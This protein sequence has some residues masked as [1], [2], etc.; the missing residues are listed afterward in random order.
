MTLLTLLPHRL[1]AVA[2][3]SAICLPAMAAELEGTPVPVDASSQVDLQIDR[4]TPPVA[5]PP[6]AAVV[7]EKAP[8]PVDE[9][10]NDQKPEWMQE[11]DAQMRESASDMQEI[12]ASQ[13]E[14]A[15]VEAQVREAARHAQHQQHWQRDLEKNLQQAFGGHAS[16]DSENNEDEEFPAMVAVIAIFGMFTGVM[17]LCSPLILIG[18]YLTLRYRARAR[19]QQELNSNIDKLLAAGRDIPVEILR[20]D[21]PRPAEDHGNLAKG[22]RNIC[23]GTGWFVFLTIAFSVKVGAL[24]FI[25][26]ALGIS[27]ALIWYLNK[28]AGTA[29]TE[30]QVGQQD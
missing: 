16:R 18:F 17:I 7:P 5:P 29:A 6:P 14:V 28:P 21:D 27:Q 26:I 8:P 15:A 2:L 22:V 23:L 20:G 9:F 19:R 3:A 13:G 25:W 30:L 11:H 10:E 24:G 1:C 12:E 4:D